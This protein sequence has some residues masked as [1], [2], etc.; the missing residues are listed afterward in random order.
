MLGAGL[1]LFAAACGES[2]GGADTTPTSIATDLDTIPDGYGSGNL[3]PEGLALAPPPTVG[4]EA[5]ARLDDFAAR[6]VNDGRCTTV[7]RHFSAVVVSGTGIGCLQ[8]SDLLIESGLLDADP[9]AMRS[10]RDQVADFA[11]QADRG[12]GSVD[13]YNGYTVLLVENLDSTF[14]IAVDTVA[15]AEANQSINDVLLA[16]GRFTS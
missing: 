5:T 3:S 6:M 12:R 11:D 16:K 15:S 7:R 14:T 1:G 2:T 10:A 13:L 9:A 8:A 4:N